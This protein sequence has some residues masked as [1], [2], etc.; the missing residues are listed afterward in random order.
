MAQFLGVSFMN[1]RLL[2]LISFL[3]FASCAVAL[4]VGQCWSYAAMPGEEASCVVIRKIETLPKI[5]EVIH[6]SIFGVKIKSPAPPDGF[7]DQV[8]HLPIAGANL[9]S[10]LKERVQKKVPDADW[11]G[12]Y[13][14]WRS[15]YDSGKAGVFTKSISECV[16]YLEEALNHGNKG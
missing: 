4:Q 2:T 13:R 15:A 9:R 11:E 5:G 12:G 3:G 16:G 6:I 10:S 7:T 1:K 14:M 8:G